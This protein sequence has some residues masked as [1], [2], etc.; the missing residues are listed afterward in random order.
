MSGES[1]IPTAF[2]RDLLASWLR[3][4]AEQNVFI[5]TSSWK[6]EGWVGKLY[7][8]ENYLTRGKFSAAKFERECLNEHADVFSTVCVDAGYYRF[9]SPEWIKGIMAQTPEHYRFTFKVT[10]EITARTFAKLERHG[11]KGGQRNEHFLDA[12][13]FQAGVLAS[14]EPF[15]E[16]VG[17]LIFEFS[18]FYPHDFERGRDFVDA[19]DQ[20]FG[21]LPKGWRYAVE[22]RNRSFLQPAYFQ[23]LRSHGVS[24][25]FNQ[26]TKMPD[27]STQW[28]LPDSKT[29]DMFAASRMLLRSGRSYEEAVKLFTPYDSIKEPNEQARDTAVKMINETLESQAS[30]DPKAFFL[31]INNRL[32]GN[33]LETIFAILVRLELWKRGLAFAIKKAPSKKMLF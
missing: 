6:Y 28:N 7:D 22:I 5:G 19:L 27:V 20:F 10:D 14:L 17:V 3:W 15:R 12:H 23:M 25:V 18:K 11:N 31:Y 33:S 13:L 1:G 8:R 9:P 21:R 29:S 16:K 32:E 30:P 26:W 4:L 2:D 24:H